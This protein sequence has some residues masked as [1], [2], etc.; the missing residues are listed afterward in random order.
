MSLG[1]TPAGQGFLGQRLLQ[2]LLFRAGVTLLCVA[3]AH[4]VLATTAWAMETSESRLSSS[5]IE[6]LNQLDP[7]RPGP[8]YRAFLRFLE[9][10]EYAHSEG[11]RGIEYL[12]DL[13]HRSIADALDGVFREVK[14]SSDLEGYIGRCSSVSAARAAVEHAD[15]TAV[16]LRRALNDLTD[17]LG[18]SGSKT[19]QVE[20]CVELVE[21]LSR[22]LQDELLVVSELFAEREFLESVVEEVERRAAADKGL[23][24][25]Y[26]AVL[27]EL[28][29]RSDFLNRLVPSGP[30]ALAL[31]NSD[32]C[33]DLSGVSRLLTERSLEMAD[34]ARDGAGPAG[35]ES[36]TL[37]AGDRVAPEG[38]LPVVRVLPPAPVSASERVSLPRR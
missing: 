27:D 33:R 5:T 28:E 19:V 34:L 20:E 4:S 6:Y 25:E 30:R 3:L 26:A 16:R 9:Q 11:L 22:A 18:G 24:Q 10:V 38:S 32:A 12:A 23:G 37:S 1:R 14:A 21:L 2:R 36:P 7:D 15:D 29:E 8:A 13:G 17:I 31:L 35:L